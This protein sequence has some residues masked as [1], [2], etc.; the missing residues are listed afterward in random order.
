V[1][2]PS[3][4]GS[5]E[6]ILKDPDRAAYAELPMVDGGVKTRLFDVKILSS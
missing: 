3:R 2:L 4:F 6:P 1:T 5:E